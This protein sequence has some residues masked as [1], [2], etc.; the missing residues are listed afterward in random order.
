MSRRARIGSLILASSL[1]AGYA[2][3]L[4]RPEAY[5]ILKASIEPSLPYGTA[6]FRTDIWIPDPDDENK[7]ERLLGRRFLEALV[8]EG[9]LRGPTSRP[10]TL[11]WTPGVDYFFW[12][13]AGP[14]V[15]PSQEPRVVLRASRGL[16]SEVAGI[17][18]DGP[19]WAEVDCVVLYTPTQTYHAVNR[20]VA[21]YRPKVGAGWRLP[22]SR[23]ARGTATV[24]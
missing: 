18:S 7:A 21:F 19:N 23:L 2:G 8:G 22:L 5:R 1:L 16:I 13:N 24:Y 12:P 10:Y 9:I 4:T 11:I 6:S 14:E 17:A 20:H 3:A 15:E